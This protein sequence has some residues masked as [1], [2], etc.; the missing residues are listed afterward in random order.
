MWGRGCSSSLN[1]RGS[2][3]GMFSTFIIESQFNSN[4]L[5]EKL[6]FQ[7][8]FRIKFKKHK[9]NVQSKAFFFISNEGP[10]RVLVFFRFSLNKNVILKKIFNNVHTN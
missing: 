1:G 7:I 8:N 4:G 3:G 6:I 2:W 9:S 10:F 5:F